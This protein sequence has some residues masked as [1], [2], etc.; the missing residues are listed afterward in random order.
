MHL[1]SSSLCR[2]ESPDASWTLNHEPEQYSKEPH[3]QVTI[4]PAAL[5]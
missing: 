2:L 3:D 5:D 1:L 4:M